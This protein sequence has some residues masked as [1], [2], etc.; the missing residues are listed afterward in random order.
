[1]K[2]FLEPLNL[3]ALT[4]MEAGQLMIRHQS[5]LNTI[6]ASLLT[7]APYNSYV[8]KIGNQTELYYNALAQVRKNEETEK[9]G[10]ADVV[11]DKAIS[12]FNLALKLHASADD[13]AEAEASR[14]LKILFDTFKNIAKL[15]YEAET[16]AI[17][18]LVNDL[19]G[20]AYSE[21]IA[22][23]HMGKYVT[24]LN[25]TNDAFRTLFSGRMVD[26]AMSESFDMKTIRKELM[27]TYTDFAEYV[28]AMAKATDKQLF[29]TALNLLNAARKY[30]ANQMLSNP[31][32]KP[33]TPVD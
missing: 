21:K 26:T 25:E 7:D 32:P 11:R 12:S 33:E 5:D 14:S 3:S 19:N 18:K 27:E 28:L 22:S 9:I 29:S 13:P 2:P 15:N 30:Y 16:L 8:T 23:L 17:D 20:E 6:D 10:L 31:A 1:M 24:R 4:N